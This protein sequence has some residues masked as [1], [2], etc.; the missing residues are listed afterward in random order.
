MMLRTLLALTA[1]CARA[2][3]KEPPKTVALVSFAAPWD[4]GPYSHQLRELS[5]YW[6]KTHH[7]VWIGLSGTVDK[8][9]Y[10]AP[11]ISPRVGY[12][13]AGMAQDPVK[14]V[15]KLNR[16]FEQEGIDFCITLCDLNNVGG[17]EAFGIPAIAWFP[18][19]TGELDLASAHALRAYDAVAA[20]SPSDARSI[21]RELPSKRVARIPHVVDGRSHVSIKDR[22]QL[23][24]KWNIPLNAFVPVMA[25]GNYAS[26]DRKGVDVA[27]LAYADFCRSYQKPSYL[28]VRAVTIN[29]SIG[30]RMAASLPVSVMF[31]AAGVP[32]SRYFVDTV[33]RAYAESLE[34]IAFADV[35]LHP[36]RSEG[37]GML[38]LEAQ[39]IGLPVITTKRGAMK[40]YTM[41]GISV[42]PLQRE[43]LNIGYVATPDVGG[44]A[45]ALRSVANGT[46]CSLNGE[47]E[48]AVDVVSNSMSRQAV[49]ANF[50]DLLNTIKERPL[51]P[52]IL[53]YGSTSCGVI[54]EQDH[55]WVVVADKQH[56]LDA[57]ALKTAI[58]DLN[59]REDTPSIV[60]VKTLELYDKVASPFD[61]ASVLNIRPVALARAGD[62]KRAMGA[63]SSSTP[64]DRAVDAAVAQLV[65]RADPA[66]VLLDVIAARRWVDPVN[67]PRWNA[68]PAGL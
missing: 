68:R 7:V 38:V 5:T 54:E 28:Y 45:D 62:L 16:I 58:E 27:A 53:R 19:H 30:H 46:C 52:S 64:I 23:R 25:F 3:K 60:V 49:G 61:A 9:Q 10:G 59:L 6:L 44:V 36:S 12:R 65:K 55:E 41:H 26:D 15:S 33:E 35:L 43:W 17:D 24:K 42:K 8:I 18:S 56:V 11:K 63:V 40:D 22:D 29:A 34:V 48:R 57:H 50:D 31:R 67:N 1:A 37:F 47:R 66:D 2:K 51:L 39:H 13:G 21:G 20:L 32:Q 4:Y 14:K